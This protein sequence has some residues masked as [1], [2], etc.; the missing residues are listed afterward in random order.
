MW[1]QEELHW[2]QRSQLDWLTASDRNIKFFQTSTVQRWRWNQLV[3]IRGADGEWIQEDK[4]LREEVLFYFRNLYTSEQILVAPELVHC[5]DRC[6]TQEMNNSFLAPIHEDEI[7]T[8]V[9]NLGKHKAPPDGFH[10]FFFQDNWEL[11]KH[12]VIR[13]VQEFY[14]TGKMNPK[15]NHT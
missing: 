4:K 2:K 6:V 1:E 11:V 5:I 7:R 13:L 15:L 3:K 12:D 14:A 9:F 10:G 8:A